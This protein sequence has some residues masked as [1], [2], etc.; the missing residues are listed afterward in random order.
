MAAGI[1]WTLQQPRLFHTGTDSSQ[2]YC[3]LYALCTLPEKGGYASVPHADRHGSAHQYTDHWRLMRLSVSVSYTVFAELLLVT[4]AFY[5]TNVFI[6]TL[7]HRFA[8]SN[9][10]VMEQ[11]GHWR[12]PRWSGVYT[13]G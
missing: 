9:R 3:I 7:Y 1:G 6:L 10:K 5:A 8:Q 2:A 12:T 11:E 4:I 13:G